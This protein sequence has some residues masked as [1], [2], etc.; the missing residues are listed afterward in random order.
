MKT[1]ID[2]LL[3]HI[4]A[5]NL[6]AAGAAAVQAVASED[7]RSALAQLP[8]SIAKTELSVSSFVLAKE[9][10]KR[11]AQE[12]SDWLPVFADFLDS[13]EGI[14][15]PAQVHNLA[16]SVAWVTRGQFL[17][18][19]NDEIRPGRGQQFGLLVALEQRRFVFDGAGIQNLLGLGQGLIQEASPFHDLIDAYEFFSQL[20]QDDNRRDA[21]DAVDH[22]IQIAKRSSIQLRVFDIIAHAIW[23]AKPFDEQGVLLERVCDAWARIPEGSDIVVNFRRAAALRM[24][25]RYLDAITT[26]QTVIASISGS[27]EFHKTFAEQ[28]IRERELNVAAL[29]LEAERKKSVAEIE[30]VRNE[31]SEY[32]RRAN[33]RTIEVVTL[34]AAAAAFALGAVS[35]ISSQNDPSVVLILL[36]GYGAGLAVFA[37]VTVVS[38]SFMASATRDDARL[39]KATLVL[40]SKIVFLVMAQFGLAYI[41]SE[42]VF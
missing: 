5:P 40:L 20:V 35:L 7:L 4:T 24:Q 41:V 9:I 10:F 18:F 37:G 11:I 29:A 17:D 32:E 36:G 1:Q 12:Q 30:Q 13:T 3:K 19:L 39:K 25:H 38:M 28:C 31:L 42:L 2:E 23:L 33:T 6:D 21:A 26:I 16:N 14:L 34:F 22:V 8:E 27:S 15:N